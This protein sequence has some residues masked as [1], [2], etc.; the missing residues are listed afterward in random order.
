MVFEKLGPSLYDFL[1]RNN[2]QPFPIA[3]VQVGLWPG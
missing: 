2:Y 3:V 1:R